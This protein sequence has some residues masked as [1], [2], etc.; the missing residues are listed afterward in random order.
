MDQKLAAADIGQA[1]DRA[2]QRGLAAAGGTHHA[3][4]LVALDGERELMEGDDGSIEKKFAH[5]LRNNGG[6]VACIR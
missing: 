4:D 5:P 3:H 6:L 2:Q 1:R